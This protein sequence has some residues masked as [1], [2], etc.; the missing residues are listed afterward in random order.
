MLL[1]GYLNILPDHG[2][3]GAW[4]ARE[5]S[6]SRGWLQHVD[7][8]LSVDSKC[9]GFTREAFNVGNVED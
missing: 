2:G 9:Q 5:V 8:F 7:A 1:R 3:C 6:I 4:P